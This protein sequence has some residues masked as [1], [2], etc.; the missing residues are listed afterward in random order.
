MQRL[1]QSLGVLDGRQI[2]QQPC[3]CTLFGVAA[4]GS[5]IAIEDALY[6]FAWNW[7]EN[8]VAV[9]GKTLP[10]G[11]TQAQQ[12]LVALMPGIETAVE[13]AMQLQDDEL[14][15]TLPGFALSSALHETQ[16]SR[17]FRS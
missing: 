1:L 7:L 9:A 4:A 3:W 5:G 15:A 12:L 16:Y 10:L 2:P 8:Q 17:L 14:G 6:G 13:A 11:Q